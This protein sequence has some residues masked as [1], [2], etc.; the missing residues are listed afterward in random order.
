MLQR[1]FH[2]AQLALRRI[3][4]PY[5]SDPPT[6]GHNKAEPVLRVANLGLSRQPLPVKIVVLNDELG[7]TLRH[8]DLNVIA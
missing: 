1:P 4:A 5:L 2:F 3:G 6:Q 8:A 7:K